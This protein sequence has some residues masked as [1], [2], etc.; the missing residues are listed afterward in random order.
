VWCAIDFARR[1]TCVHQPVS[2]ATGLP[3]SSCRATAITSRMWPSILTRCST[4][5]SARRPIWPAAIVAR[6]L[7]SVND[8]VT[9]GLDAPTRW[10]P[11]SLR[12]IGVES[13]STKDSI[14][15]TKSSIGPDSRECNCKRSA[16]PQIR[17]DSN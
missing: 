14:L 4:M 16:S 11:G 15:R 8:S 13:C 6:L 12:A 5:S 1:I 3:G 9:A 2:L 17:V 7:Q 10:P